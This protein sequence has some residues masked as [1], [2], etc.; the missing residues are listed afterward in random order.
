M[1]AIKPLPH[2]SLLGWAGL[3]WAGLGWAGLGWVVFHMSGHPCSMSP[4]F[5]AAHC[6]GCC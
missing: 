4:S 3:G 2:E 1:F 6:F 5:S